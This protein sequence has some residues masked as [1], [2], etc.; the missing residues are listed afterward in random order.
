MLKRGF[1]KVGDIVV[2]T[3]KKITQFAAWVSLDE[4]E[5][6]RGLIHISEVAGKW[7]KDIRKYIKVGKMYVVKVMDVDK[8][9]NLV[10]LSLRRVSSFERKE[11]LREYKTEKRVFS[12]LKQVAKELKKENELQNVVENIFEKYKS[13]GEFLEDLREDKLKDIKLSEEWINKIKEIIEKSKKEKIFT[14]KAEITLQSY[15]ADGIK[16]IKDALMELENQTNGKV[17][18]IS[19][20]TYLLVLQ[21]KNPKKDEKRLTKILESFSKKYNAEFKMVS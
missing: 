10:K 13:L 20:P 19:A 7:I 15:E 5:N 8:K 1:P 2:C 6:L 3:V 4:Y 14:L 12:I 17:K 18:Y 21:T 16:K 9:S 11:K